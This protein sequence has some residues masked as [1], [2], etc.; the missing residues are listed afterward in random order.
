MGLS[1]LGIGLGDEVILADTNW[2]ATAAPIIHIG[3]QPVFVDIK[4]DSWC[5][6]PKQ[7]IKAITPNTGNHC[8]TSLWKSL[9][10]GRVG[11]YRSTTR[12]SNH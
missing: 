1:A 7:V 9:R 4:S 2:V 3:A 8:D 10:D 11:R 12:L 6:D 5:I